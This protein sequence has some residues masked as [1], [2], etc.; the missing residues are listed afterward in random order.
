MPYSFIESVR[1]FFSSAPAL[2]YGL[3]VC[4][5]ALF[6]FSWH[7]VLLIPVITLFLLVEK[8]RAILGLLTT[9]VFWFFASNSSIYPPSWADSV[10]GVATFEITDFVHEI[11]YS[12]PYTKLKIDL[13]GFES[14]ENSFFAKNIPCKLVWNHIG[15][16]PKADGIYRAKGSLQHHEGNWTLKLDKEP[17]LEKLKETYSLVE[18]RQRLKATMKTTLA[19]YLAPGQTRALLEGVLLGEFHDTQLKAALNRFSLQHITVVSGFHFSL[20][21]LIM[22]SFFRLLLPW[23]ITNI[24]LLLGVTAYLLFIGPSASVLRAY[25]AT[26]VLFLGK[27]LE[28][29]SNGLNALGLGLMVVLTLDPASI[30]SLA[31]TLSFLATFAILLL[32]PTLHKAIRS[33]FPTRNLSEVLKMPFLDQLYFVLLTF[34][35]SS[36][37]LV[38]SVSIFMLPMSLYAFGQFPLLGMVYNCFF[39]FCVSIAMF[40]VAFAF[41]F[42]WVAPFATFLFSIAA[43]IL[44]CSLTLVTHAP[45]WCDLTIHSPFPGTLLVLYF[46][47]ITCL[48]IRYHARVEA[49]L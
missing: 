11:R 10:T 1:R 34:F 16:R 25:V 22:A 33:L 23:R 30:T 32:Y 13:I 38:T 46:T 6:A 49:S 14:D 2:F 29:Q 31:F 27:C 5:G 15:T 4:F 41:L 40:V 19:K 17:A 35:I 20:I 36:V 47:L 21:A 9:A 48:G 3:S 18:W 39:P 12:R 24:C 26:M 28:R 43:S 42:I 45:S 37:A 7:P 8:E 44:D